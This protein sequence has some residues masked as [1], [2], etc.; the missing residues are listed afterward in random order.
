[1]RSVGKVQAFTVV[2]N[3]RVGSAIAEMGSKDVSFP[4]HHGAWSVLSCYTWHLTG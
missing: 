4:N 1:M 3:G 2:G